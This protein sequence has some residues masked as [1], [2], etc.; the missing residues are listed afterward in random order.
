MTA[1]LMTA[2]VSPNGMGY[3]ALQDPEERA[4]QYVEAIEFYLRET[5]LDIVFC[6]NTGVNLF[7]RVCSPAKHGRLECLAFCGNDYDRSRGKSYGEGVIVAYALRHSER[8]RRCSRV[9]KITGRVKIHNLGEM[10]RIAAG[11]RSSEYIVAELSSVDWVKS[12]CLLAPA[13][14]LLS[15]VERY[16]PRLHDIE[17]NFEKMLFRSIVESR[18]MKVCRWFPKI[19]GVLGVNGKPY[20]SLPPVERRLCHWDGLY[21]LYKMRGDVSAMLFARAGWFCCLVERKMNIFLRKR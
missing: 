10:L 19:E 3:T 12:V 4:A 13:E 11:Q 21:H 9:I 16:G 17:F 1:I 5:D 7:D 18:G 14:W 8:L 15:T 2:T 20:P 6:E